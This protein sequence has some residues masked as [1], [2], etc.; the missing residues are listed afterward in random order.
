MSHEALVV[1]GDRFEEFLANRGTVGATALLERLR[2]GDLPE[3]LSLSVGQGLTAGELAEL[4]ELAERRAPAVTLGKSGVPAPAERRLTH[5]HDAR[6]ILVGPVGQ[7]AENRFVADLVLDQRVEVLADH[8]TGQHIPAITLLEAA[9]QMWTVVTEQ[10]FITGADRTRFVVVSVASRFHSYVFPLA[11]T[12]QYELLEHTRTPVGTVFRCRIGIHHGT[13]AAA[14][15]E[16]EYRVI[17][18]KVSAKQEA[19]AARQAVAAEVGLLRAQA[20]P[21][22]APTA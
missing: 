21:A 18:D 17:P 9:R 3:S 2:A 19:I 15:V 10:F 1:V 22:E 7:I 6:N 20:S 5:K 14:E 8:L 12:L 11:A 16:A 4:R 13:P